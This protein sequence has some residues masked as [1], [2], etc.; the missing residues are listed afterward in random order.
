GEHAAKTPLRTLDPTRRLANLDFAAAP[1]ELLSSPD[2]DAARSRVRD[3]AA[4]ALSAEQLGG[5]AKVLEMTAEYAKV[6]VQFGRAI[7]SYQ[8]VKHRLAD[9]HSALE[10]AGAAV[11]YAAWA[12]DADPQELPLAAALVQVLVAPANFQAAADAVQLHGGIG[13]TWE[14]DAHLYYKRAKASELLLG[15]PDQNRA[16]L[17]DLLQI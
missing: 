16:R 17:A 8:G 10:Q 2:P 4:V 11:R 3:L 6:R 13:Y 7:G 14:H 5:M 12:A 9:M 15:T 1:A